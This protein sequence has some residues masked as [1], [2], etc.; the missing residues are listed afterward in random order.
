MSPRVRWFE[1]ARL[2]G[3]WLN[4]DEIKIK[5]DWIAPGSTFSHIFC[6]KND[7]SCIGQLWPSLCR[8]FFNLRWPLQCGQLV[9]SEGAYY[10]VRTREDFFFLWLFMLLRM[11]LIGEKNLWNKYSL[12]EDKKTGEKISFILQEGEEWK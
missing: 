8:I 3:R 7:H 9:N 2:K 1:Q 5:V 4:I 6:C 11:K 10:Q 12:T